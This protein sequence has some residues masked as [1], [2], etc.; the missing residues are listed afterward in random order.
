MKSEL[1]EHAR[2]CLTAS[3]AITVLLPC[4]AAHAQ[5]ASFTGTYTG[6][7]NNS[8]MC[9]TTFN[10]LGREPAT[11]VHPVFI[12]TVGTG[13]SFTDALATTIVN[14]MAA[15]GFVSASIE[16]DNDAFGGNTR[17]GTGKARCIYD[18]RSAASAVAKLCARATADC[19]K[20]IVVAGL[21]QGSVLAELAA[22]FDARVRAAWGLG[23]GVQYAFINV[24]SAVADGNRT[25]PSSRLRVINGEKDE[26]LAGDDMTRTQNQEL[27]GLNC[28]TAQSCLQPNGS[29]WY[30]VFDSQ[31]QDGVA[32][33]CYMTIGGCVNGSLL[34]PTFVN[35]TAPWS[36]GPNLDFLQ[37]FTQP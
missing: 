6:Q 1:Q 13:E 33:H 29:G 16:Y 8:T 20:G 26:F 37:S 2:H 19:N 31:V 15:R 23:A 36:L 3:L 14:A 11:G 30:I 4:M 21:S 10:L 7:G 17:T 28:G 18:G 22:N 12:W 5:T 34:D 24:R 32:D 35:G 27:T 9:N 25:L